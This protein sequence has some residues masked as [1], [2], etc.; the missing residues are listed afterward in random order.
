[1]IESNTLPKTNT[2]LSSCV[3]DCARPIVGART[4]AANIIAAIPEM[5]RCFITISFRKA[6]LSISRLILLGNND[7]VKLVKPVNIF[8]KFDVK[9]KTPEPSRLDSDERQLT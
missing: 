1:M 7:Y 4:A 5:S 6:R 9:P 8:P 3:L 2:P